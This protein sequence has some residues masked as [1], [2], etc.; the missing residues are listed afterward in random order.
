MNTR[1]LN[2]NHEISTISDNSE[3]KSNKK[4]KKT[5]ILHNLSPKNIT[6][7]SY[8]QLYQKKVGGNIF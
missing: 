7:Q 5:L 1:T 3:K 2:K 4:S 6:T 8:M